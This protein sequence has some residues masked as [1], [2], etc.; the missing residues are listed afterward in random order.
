MES[1]FNRTSKDYHPR[2]RNCRRS[3]NP[4]TGNKSADSTVLSPNFNKRA[5]EEE[6]SYLDRSR[7]HKIKHFILNKNKADI[8]I[9]KSIT[10]HSTPIASRVRQKTN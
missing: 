8:F 7:I 3:N 2:T 4:V 5:H 6:C 9:Q 10:Q 1:T